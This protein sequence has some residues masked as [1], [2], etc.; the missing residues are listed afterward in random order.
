[1]CVCVCGRG[2]RPV[3]VYLMKPSQ[4]LL[5]S[6]PQTTTITT[7]SSSPTVNS[8]P[9]TVNSSSPT[10]NSSTP[11]LSTERDGSL[12][13]RISIGVSSAVVVL[14]AAAVTMIS[15]TVY[16]KK[17]NKPMHEADTMKMDTNVA[18]VTSNNDMEMSG[19]VSYSI[20]NCASLNN[21]EMEMSSNVSYSITNGK[22][23]DNAYDYAYVSTSAENE[24]GIT[25]CPNEAYTTAD[26]ILASSNQAYGMV[27]D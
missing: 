3:D 14:I 20:A 13:L 10:V 9:P 17:Q 2:G 1:M 5:Y 26:N 27:H 24:I 22:D 25:T 6:T 18:Y 19:N 11:T 8:S 21:K 15:V 7:S 4:L 12:L 16:L 23:E